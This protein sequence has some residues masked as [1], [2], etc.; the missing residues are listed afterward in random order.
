MQ[1]EGFLSFYKG[2]IVLYS[3]YSFLHS[4]TFSP[5]IGYGLQNSL[6]FGFNRFFRKILATINGGEE[7]TRTLFFAGILTG[8][9]SALAIVR[10]DELDTC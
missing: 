7:T 5:L 9:P 6:Q 3:R 2:K 1:E 4:G 10:L 8:I